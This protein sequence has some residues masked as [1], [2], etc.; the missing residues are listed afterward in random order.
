M[1]KQLSF[2]AVKTGSD[3]V[4]QARGQDQGRL[5]EGDCSVRLASSLG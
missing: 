4:K 3:E 1:K 5:T 2:L